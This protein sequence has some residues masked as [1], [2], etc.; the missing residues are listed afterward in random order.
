MREAKSQV[1]LFHVQ[2]RTKI[3]KHLR[4]RLE[5][6]NQIDEDRLAGMKARLEQ[7]GAGEVSTEIHYGL[8]SEEI[9]NRARQGDCTM[10]LMGA[11]GRGYFAEAFLG[12]VA[13][14][15]ARLAPLPVLLVP[16]L[17]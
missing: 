7:C 3:E 1:V 12:S 11:Q 9:L 10:I 5:E 8:P 2:V 16:A 6:F 14:H 17:R 15:V 13:S 4:H